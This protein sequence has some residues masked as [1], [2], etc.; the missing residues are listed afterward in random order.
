MHAL[1]TLSGLGSIYI[2]LHPPSPSKLAAGPGQTHKRKRGAAEQQM[3][4]E[5]DEAV[6]RNEDITLPEEEVSICLLLA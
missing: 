5:E 3:V 6:A 2:P 1:V 4:L